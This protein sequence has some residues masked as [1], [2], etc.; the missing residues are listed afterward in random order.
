MESINESIKCLHSS[1]TA[2][3][4][5]DRQLFVSNMLPTMD[6]EVLR[7]IFESEKYTEVESVDL[8]E[9]ERRTDGTQVRVPGSSHFDFVCRWRW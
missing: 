9:D 4:A 6:Q 5:I 2:N 3:T 7:A 1:V 8:H